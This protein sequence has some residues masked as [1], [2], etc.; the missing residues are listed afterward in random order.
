MLS[1]LSIA[2]ALGF[3]TTFPVGRSAESFEA[4]R[5]RVYVMPLAGI[6][7]GTICGTICY[8]LGILSLGFLAPLAILAVEGINHLDG[9]SDFGDALFAHGERKLK[10]LK[11]LNTG[12]GGTVLLTL[13]CITVSLTAWKLSPLYLFFTA[14]SA[15]ISA[16]SCMLLTLSTSKPLWDGMGKY[17]MEFADARATLSS[18]LA[19]VLM[20]ALQYS[21]SF[22]FLELF[23]ASMLGCLL[24][25][26]YSER[27]FGG[28]N[29]DVVGAVNC[30]SVAVCFACAW[31]LC[32]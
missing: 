24:V 27:A 4:F 14:L 18:V 20:L 11:D 25:K 19:G 13:W 1:V 32:C 31:C 12:A 29:G 9:L 17:M 7:I 26:V 16:K 10:A 22:P 6:I 2:G 30:I 8:I 15:E 21:L 28:V 23:L 5:R 3:L